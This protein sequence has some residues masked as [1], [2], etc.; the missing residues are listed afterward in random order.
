MRSIFLSH[1]QVF[2]K[3]LPVFKTVGTAAPA[4]DLA[5][6]TT[7]GWVLTCTGISGAKQIIA[8]NKDPAAQIFASASYAVEGDCVQF[9]K[10][11]ISELRANPPMRTIWGSSEEYNG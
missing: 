7:P 1:E 6:L 10:S 4:S 2:E 8:V 9:M 5:L 11:L 3:Q